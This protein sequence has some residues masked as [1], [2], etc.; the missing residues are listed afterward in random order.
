[1]VAMK[2]AKDNATKLLGDLTLEYNKAR[3]AA[4]TQEI[5]EIAA[6]SFAG[7]DPFLGQPRPPFIVMSNTGK[8]VQVIGPVV[9]VQ[10]AENS[11]PPIYQALTID[12]DRLRQAGRSPSRCS[13]TSAAASP[14]RSPCPPPRA[15]CAAWK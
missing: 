4:I 14:A 5:L 8:I 7:P 11:I 9:D 13:S 1:M 10:F 15:S 12:F 3:Q 6:A 2:T